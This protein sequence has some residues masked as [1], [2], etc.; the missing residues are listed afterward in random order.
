[1]DG[2]QSEGNLAVFAAAVGGVVGV[3]AAVVAAHAVGAAGVA[4]AAAA[5]AAAVPRGRRLLEP[6]LAAEEVVRHAVLAQGVE[7]GD[8][9]GEGSCRS[10]KKRPSSLGGFAKVYLSEH[11][12]QARVG[13]AGVGDVEDLEGVAERV[14]HLLHLHQT[15]FATSAGTAATSAG[16]GNI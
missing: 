8:L 13:D 2:V 16:G 3:A 15:L 1:M 7:V 11:D 12:Q 6:R 9:R 10:V 14:E 4:S 5:A